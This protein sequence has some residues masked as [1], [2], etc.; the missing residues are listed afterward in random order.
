[1]LAIT[2]LHPAKRHAEVLKDPATAREQLG[3]D[4]AP[5]SFLPPCEEVTCV[6]NQHEEKGI[7][8]Y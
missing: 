1:M 3:V 6:A 5:I 8:M 4:Q 7:P 2:K